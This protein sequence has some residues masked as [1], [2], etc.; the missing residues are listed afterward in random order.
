MGDQPQRIDKRPA[1]FDT[2]LDPET[3]DGSGTLTKVLCRALPFGAGRQSGIVDPAYLDVFQYFATAKAFSEW[4]GIRRCKVSILKQKC[5][6]GGQ[7]PRSLSRM[8]G[9]MI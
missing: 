8:T 6:K 7:R 9:L 1:C 2:A 4:R 5:I 3:E